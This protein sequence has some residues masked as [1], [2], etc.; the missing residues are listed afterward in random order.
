MT[1]EASAKRG[2]GR[3]KK[4]SPEQAAELARLRAERVPWKDLQARYGADRATLH[5]AMPRPIPGRAP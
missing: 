5:R 1:L 3:P 2:R 4:L